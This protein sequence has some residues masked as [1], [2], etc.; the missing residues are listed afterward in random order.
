MN[1]PLHN[2]YILMKMEEKEEFELKK[3]ATLHNSKGMNML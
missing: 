2:E 3:R 1:A